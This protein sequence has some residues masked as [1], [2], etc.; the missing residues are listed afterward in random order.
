M[1]QRV[2][3]MAHETQGTGGIVVKKKLSIGFILM[4]A[5]ML[6]G[7]IALAATLLWQDAG[8]KVAPMESENESFHLSILCNRGTSL[9]VQETVPFDQLPS[10]Q[11]PT[12][13]AGQQDSA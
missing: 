10:M 13:P 9:Q 2:L 1:A 11:R 12:R 5:V 3:N 8:E 7:V 4:M 6:L